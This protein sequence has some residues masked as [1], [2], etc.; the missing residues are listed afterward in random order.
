MT[1]VPESRRRHH[2]QIP[3]PPEQPLFEPQF[4]KREGKEGDGEDQRQFFPATNG[5]GGGGGGDQHHHHNDESASISSTVSKWEDIDSGRIDR[6]AGFAAGDPAGSEAPVT[7][8]R[9]AKAPTVVEEEKEEAEEEFHE[10]P[11]ASQVRSNRGF[12]RML[13]PTF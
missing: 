2:H 13:F 8:G 10:M 9:V 11:P 3:P 4:M 5:G 1:F 6:I 7:N 12:C